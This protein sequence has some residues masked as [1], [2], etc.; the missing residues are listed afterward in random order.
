MEVRQGTSRYLTSYLRSLYVAPEVAR[1]CPLK[2]IF[3]RLSLARSSLLARWPA[4]PL[5]LSPAPSPGV[6]SARGP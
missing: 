5:A 4:D 2:A 3:S 1:R 6:R